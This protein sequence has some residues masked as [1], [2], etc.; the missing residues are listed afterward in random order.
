MG[1]LEVSKEGWPVWHSL[2]GRVTLYQFWDNILVAADTPPQHRARV[3]QRVREV[4]MVAWDLQVECDCISKTV[5]K[6]TG[7]CCQHV[8]KAVGVVM[9]LGGRTD[10][11]AFAEPAA[12]TSTWDLKLGI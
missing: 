6:C 1:C 9:V 5:P 4:L 2:E 12:L 3:I 10:A 7:A 8:T 11:T